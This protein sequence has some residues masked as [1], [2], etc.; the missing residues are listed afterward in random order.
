MLITFTPLSFG[1]LLVLIVRVKRD[2]GIDLRQSLHPLLTIAMTYRGE[3][4]NNYDF[5]P[6]VLRV[7]VT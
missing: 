7:Y 3:N 2:F 5:H 6:S 4:S 1:H